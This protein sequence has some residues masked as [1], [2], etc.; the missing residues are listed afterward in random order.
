TDALQLA[1]DT[2]NLPALGQLVQDYPDRDYNNISNNHASAL[3]WSLMPP[4]GKRIEPK[5]VTYLLQ[6]APINPEQTLAGY[7]PRQYL[8]FACTQ[9][10]SDIIL[11][12]LTEA[13]RHF[14][15][16]AAQKDDLAAFHHQQDLSTF[17]QALEEFAITSSTSTSF[18][19]DEL[20]QND[21]LID[22]DLRGFDFSYTNLANKTFVRCILPLTGP[23]KLPSTCKLIDCSVPM[24]HTYLRHQW[25]ALFHQLCKSTTPPSA[26]TLF[27][28]LEKDAQAML[29]H[30]DRYGNTPLI[31][32]SGQKYRRTLDYILKH[33]ACDSTI[34]HQ[35]A[36]NGFNALINATVCKNASNVNAILEHPD[37]D[38]HLLTH[39][40]RD[41]NT[42]FMCAVALESDNGEIMHNIFTHRYAP[43]QF[44]LTQH[45]RLGH[46]ALSLAL[47]LN[48]KFQSQSQSIKRLLS[49]GQK[50]YPLALI[51][52]I[53]TIFRLEAHIKAQPTRRL[54][55][56]KKEH[57]FEQ[58]TTLKEIIIFFLRS[59]DHANEQKAQKLFK[60]EYDLLS[61]F[62]Q[63]NIS[64][65]DALNPLRKAIYQ[66]WQD[67][68]GLANLDKSHS[69]QQIVKITC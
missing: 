7:T 63:A 57:I 22:K 47:N 64:F 36:L 65:F 6:H 51:Q 48:I 20:W 52:L 13:E 66:H 35:T 9:E 59:I 5:I 4:R 41:G 40:N 50:I 49:Y 46:H 37:C 61:K 18:T 38:E 69:C 39:Q 58:T 67:L 27:C 21:E 12:F 3:W 29:S 26:F 54:A 28:L 62:L 30:H 23:K 8:T 45:N 2:A 16:P 33:P 19:L 68:T 43:Q 56:A 14:N 25:P 1:I 55:D 42:A 34:L 10:I 44:L 32:A 60:K 31:S 11:P 24:T 17:V 53:N 15:K